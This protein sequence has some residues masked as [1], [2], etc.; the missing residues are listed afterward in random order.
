VCVLAAPG[1]RRD[2]DIAEIARLAAGHFDKYICRQDDRTRGRPDGEIAR[3]LSEGLIA[4]GVDSA[5]ITLI[6]SEQQAVDEALLRCTQG[7]I[8]L[9]FADKITRTWKQIIYFH[10]SQQKSSVAEKSFIQNE[11]GEVSMESVMDFAQD[12][13][14]VFLVEQSD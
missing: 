8:L 9:I 14:G 13:R 10:D 11:L 12:E 3:L 5:Q 2:Q 6:D 4:A 7:D 1:D